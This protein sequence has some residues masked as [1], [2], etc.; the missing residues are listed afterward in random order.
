MVTSSGEWTL[1]G[2]AFDICDPTRP[3]GQD[4]DI[5]VHGEKPTTRR[6]DQTFN[7][8][9]TCGEEKAPYAITLESL[10]SQTEEQLEST[11]VPNQ[12]F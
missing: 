2:D 4:S 10:S 9:F 3:E 8:T 1:T 5:K 12:T 7:Y 6:E 11:F